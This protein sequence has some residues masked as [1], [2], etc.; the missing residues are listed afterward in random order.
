VD[1]V[2]GQQ[3]GA[4]AQ[5]NIPADA[6]HPGESGA[7]PDPGR[8]HRFHSQAQKEVE[9]EKRPRLPLQEAEGQDA[10]MIP[11]LRKDQAV[12]EQKAE[13]NAGR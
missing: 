5:G 8:H 4:E 10:E 12:E 3:A 7:S 9:E 11:V 6:A 1:Q 2:A 13:N